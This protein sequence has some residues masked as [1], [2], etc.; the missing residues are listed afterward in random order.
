MGTVKRRGSPRLRSRWRWRRTVRWQPALDDAAPIPEAAEDQSELLPLAQ[1]SLEPPADTDRQP[2]PSVPQW[3]WVAVAVAV[4]IIVI[5]GIVWWV[6]H[7][8]SPTGQALWN[9]E[10]A[11]LETIPIKGRA[12]K[13]GYSRSAFG[14]PWTD[15]VNVEY[16]HNG[17]D[18][19]DDI[20]RRDLI[21]ITLKPTSHGCIVLSGT[22]HDPY[23]GKTIPFHRGTPSVQIDHVVALEDAW[24]KGAQRLDVRTRQDFA[25]DPRNLQA[26]DGS[27]NQ[28][29]GGR[30]AATWLPPNKDYRCTYVSRQIDVKVLYHLWVTEAE[31]DKMK[32]LL[33]GCA[34]AA[35][36]SIR[37]TTG[38]STPRPSAPSPTSR[39][40]P[41]QG[42]FCAP[43]GSR[44]ISST[45]EPIVCS[46]AA[47]GRNRW[48]TG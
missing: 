42:Q 26:T 30:D 16:G 31:H 25:N 46:P 9:A 27:T 23:T 29:K 1:G 4:V 19:R 12:P 39:P 22:L 47:G 40:G 2:G 38:R 8:P 44:A 20:I 17:C 5:V 13:T 15:A 41:H 48:A 45:G 7:K 21:D 33:T 24:Q 32:S 18:T 3:V 35:A 11:K 37:A 10:L 34:T 36:P 43:L 28:Q 14:R 6:N